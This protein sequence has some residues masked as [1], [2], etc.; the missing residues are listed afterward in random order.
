MNDKTHDKL[1]E[2]VDAI[3]ADTPTDAEISGAAERV[4]AAIEN[5]RG[6]QTVVPSGSW[7]SIEDY[8]SAIPA[9]LNKTLT[10]QQT[11]LFDEE[12]RS[13]LPLRRALNEARG[14][15]SKSAASFKQKSRFKTMHWLASAATIA[16]LAFLLIAVSPD[17]P[18]FNQARLAQ[19][20]TVDGEI[21]QIVDGGLQELTPGS[22]IDGRQRIRSAVGSSTIITL[23]DGSEIEVDERSE[24]SMTRRG[25]GN[26]IDVSRGRILVVASPQGS[27]TLDVFTDEFMVSVTGTIFEVAHGAKGSRVAVIEGSVDVSLEGS[28]SSLVPGEALGSRSEFESLNLENEIT[29]SQDADEYIAML[30]EVSALQKDIQ[31]AIDSPERF[32]TRLLNLVPENTAAYIAVPNAPEKIAEVYEVIRTRVQNSTSAVLTNSLAEFE[33]SDESEDLETIMAWMREIG[34]T[35]GDETVLA[36]AVKDSEFTD[37]RD[38]QSENDNLIP[39][40]LSEVDADAFR[41]SFDKQVAQLI[42]SFDVE[43]NEFEIEIVIVDDASDAVD[44]QLSVLLIDDLLVATADAETLQTMQAN[45]A[46]GSSS[47]VGSELH[48][49]LES[50]YSQGTEVL[51]AVNVAKFVSPF[52]HSSEMSEQARQALEESGIDTIEYIIAQYEQQ[53]GVTTMTADMHFAGVRRG[54]MSLLASPAPMGSL[55]FFSTETTFATALLAREPSAIVE[56]LGDIRIGS[57]DSPSGYGAQTEIQLFYDIVSG[58]GGEMAFGLDGPALPTP[59]WKAVI[60]SYDEVELQTSI[61][62]A[63][64]RFNDKAVLE[65]INASVTLTPSNVDGYTGYKVDLS[66]DTSENGPAA[67]TS[68]SFNYVYVEGYLVAAANE[69]LVDRAIGFYTSGS[70]LPTDKEFQ[71]LMARDG[72]LDYSALFFSRLGEMMSGIMGSLPAV[73]SEEQ[74]QALS[75]IDEFDA[76]MGP[77]LTS[78]LAL[79][80]K[81]HVAHNG[82]SQLPTQVVSQLTALLPLIEGRRLEVEDKQAG[83]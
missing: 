23:D 49:L 46:S 39:V 4:K 12:L 63:V 82:S 34:D 45:V 44:N 55:E 29:W 16:A 40:V 2:A 19:V 5:K 1:N 74:Q 51:G 56:E 58:V 14:H 64:E 65:D 36:L 67:L 48:Q 8:I 57:D 24:L 79:P 38:T 30:Q 17:L 22:W 41:A 59:A 73:L 69:A 20:S 31:A 13:S 80:D 15:H 77:S 6:P 68:A 66:I 53:D 7:D 28:V 11:L 35:L 78:V 72:Y 60:E 47:F 43:G 61:A 76:E 70:G 32:S 10:E 37:A 26:R 33:S 81:I 27:G 42:E 75:L 50:S 83:Q 9:Y 71:D 18:S 52:A 3:K 54:I 25:S 62:A 21:Y